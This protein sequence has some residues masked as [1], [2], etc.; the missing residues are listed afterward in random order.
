MSPN[1][2]KF[3]RM[4]ESQNRSVMTN[5]N[6]YII[7]NRLNGVLY[8]GRTKSLKKRMHQHKNKV[9]PNSFSARYNLD[10]LVYFVDFET[11][12]EASIGEKQLKIWNRA[13]KIELIEKMN[14]DWKDLYEDSK[15]DKT[16]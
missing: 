13:W 11:K 1:C 2:S 15:L 9:H 7:T 5:W 3:P 14:P 8:T 10:K 4:R 12:N 16:K 6:V